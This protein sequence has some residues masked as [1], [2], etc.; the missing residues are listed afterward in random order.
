MF[1]LR[2]SGTWELVKCTNINAPKPFWS[3]GNKTNWS[4]YI[5]LGRLQFCEKALLW[6]VFN[7]YIRGVCNVN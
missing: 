4:S 3:D 1:S 6:M 2:T 5:T 7:A